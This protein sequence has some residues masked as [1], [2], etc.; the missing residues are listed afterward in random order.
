[1]AHLTLRMP[2]YTPQTTE[3]PRSYHTRHMVPHT[4]Q[5]T[6][7][8]T[9]YRTLFKLPTTPKATEHFTRFHKTDLQ[10]YRHV[11]MHKENYVSYI[12]SSHISFPNNAVEQLCLMLARSPHTLLL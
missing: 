1:M 4:P 8:S 10:Q 6:A 7:H 11:C 12:F 9:S 5:A 2:P 3:Y